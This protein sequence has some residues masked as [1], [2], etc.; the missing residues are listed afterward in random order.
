MSIL[1]VRDIQG[2]SA[3]SNTVRL[4]SGHN[5]ETNGKLTINGSLK[6]PV[7]TT[8]TRPSVLEIGSLGYNTT[9]EVLEMYSGTAWVALSTPPNRFT[10]LALWELDLRNTTIKEWKSN[11]T[12]SSTDTG[13]TRY[14]FSLG[15]TTVFGLMQNHLTGSSS[16]AKVPVTFASPRSKIYFVTWYYKGSYNSGTTGGILAASSTLFSSAYTIHPG[17]VYRDGSSGDAYIFET[18]PGS[19]EFSSANGTRYRISSG[20]NNYASG[21]HS[22]GYLFDTSTTNVGIYING[23]FIQNV[24]H[25]GSFSNFTGAQLSPW[26]FFSGYG[27]TDACMAYSM[28]IDATSLTN[29]NISTIHTTGLNN[30]VN[31]STQISTV[32]TL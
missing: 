1:S 19:S 25:S 13:Y 30:L 22:L 24:T 28:C 2:L 31:S 7:W 11:Q 29:T 10:N 17:G 8:A 27:T 12:F 6:I 9:L 14:G 5:L 4:P 23:T 16:T 3:F 21:W 18:N 15:G 26:N 32:I 20:L